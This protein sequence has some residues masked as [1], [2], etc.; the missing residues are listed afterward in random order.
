MSPLRVAL[1]VDCGRRV[2]ARRDRRRADRDGGRELLAAGNEDDPGGNRLFALAQTFDRDLAVREIEAALA[3]N[4]ARGGRAPESPANATSQKQPGDGR[5]R[6]RQFH[7]AHVESF[8][9][10][11]ITGEPETRGLGS[12]ARRSVTCS[13]MATSATVREGSRYMT[14]QPTDELVLGLSVVRKFAI[15]GRTYV[16]RDAGAHWFVRL[17][18]G[19][20]H[21]R[22]S[23]GMADWG[24]PARCARWRTGRCL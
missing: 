9:R 18:S 19:A 24:C 23:A 8:A 12:L 16:G 10:G 20:H 3:G 4:D 13:S 11:L 21:K 15:T 22:I 6:A 1:A 14:G 7:V 17:E 2:R 5:G